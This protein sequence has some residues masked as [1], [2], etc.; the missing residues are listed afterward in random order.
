MNPVNDTFQD[1]NVIYIES[2]DHLESVT[3]SQN[4]DLIDEA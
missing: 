2:D 3:E 1:T 4:F